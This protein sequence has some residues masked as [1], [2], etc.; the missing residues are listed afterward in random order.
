MRIIS[1]LY[2]FKSLF[3]T[4]LQNI[5]IIK[6]VQSYTRKKIQDREKNTTKIYN[7]EQGTYL[8]T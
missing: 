7:K 2:F 5:T 6:Q 4:F 3:L 1:F 8:Q